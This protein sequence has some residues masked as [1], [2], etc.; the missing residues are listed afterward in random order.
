MASLHFWG[1][2]SRVKFGVLWR[3]SLNICNIRNC[4]M[5]LLQY[6]AMFL[7]RWKMKTSQCTPYLMSL[8]WKASGCF[9]CSRK[10]FNLTA[11]LVQSIVLS[12]AQHCTTFIM[13]PSRTTT[14][15]VWLR[16]VFH[17]NNWCR[18]KT[19]KWKINQHIPDSFSLESLLKRDF[20][21]FYLKYRKCRSLCYSKELRAIP[22]LKKGRTFP[23][24]QDEQNPGTAEISGTLCLM[25]WGRVTLAVLLMT[26]TF[27]RKH[28]VCQ[29][30]HTTTWVPCTCAC[31]RTVLRSNHGD[32][33]LYWDS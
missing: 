29:V 23:A 4:C 30:R 25:S 16:Y 10:D 22:P 6:C 24:K 11:H 20:F 2:R 27:G 1:Q 5:L 9:H 8:T 21:V 19:H 13:H 26:N 32:V 33:F 12:L 28:L 15:K 31:F 18:F 7:Q 14:R 3:V 17:W